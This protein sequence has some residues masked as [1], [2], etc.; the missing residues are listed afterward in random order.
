[1]SKQSNNIK[2][3]VAEII[4][5]FQTAPEQA[6]EQLIFSSYYFHKQSKNFW[7]AYMKLDHDKLGKQ[8]PDSVDTFN[9]AVWLKLF[10]DLNEVY[11]TERAKNIEGLITLN[12]DETS[13][14]KSLFLC[15]ELG[16]TSNQPCS[17]PN[18]SEESLEAIK[19]LLKE[20]FPP[21]TS[22]NKT[23][24]SLEL[25]QLS[26]NLIKSQVDIALLTEFLDAFVWAGF[27]MI[28]EDCSKGFVLSLPDGK[29]KTENLFVLN[30]LK[31]LV[32]RDFK[33]KES[34]PK[35]SEEEHFKKNDPKWKT[36]E[37]LATVI[38]SSNMTVTSQTPGTTSL[39]VEDDSMLTDMTSE[40]P[41]KRDEAI[42]KMMLQS[43]EQNFHYQ[44]RHAL[45]LIY[46]PNDEIDTHALHLE[47]ETDIFVS[48]YDLLCSMS[49]IIAR[50][51]A[52]RYISEFPNSGSIKSIKRGVWDLISSQKQELT[53]QE[54]ENLTNTEVV[55]HF[56]MFDEHYEQKIFYFFSEENILDLFAKVEELKTKSQKELKAIINLLSSFNS[57]LP[58]NPLYKVDNTFYFSYHTCSKFNLNRFLYDNYISDK[59]F[60][61]NNKANKERP[62][63]EETQKNREIRFTNSLKELF[64]TITPFVESRL[65]FG[66][67]NSNYDF[68][69]LKGEFDVIAYF[70]KEN[71]IFPIQVKLSNV[72]PRSEKRKEEW[73]L[74]RITGKGIKQVKKDVKLLQTKSGL[75]FVADKLKIGNRKEINQPIIYPII[76]S[77][78]FFADHIS[79]P[80]NE[81]DDQVF[82]VSYF[83]LKHLILNQK[84]HDKQ[85]D[86]LPFDNGNSASHLIE[87]IETNVFWD[88]LNVFA[89]NFKFSKT[90][91]AINEE[92]K[93]EMKV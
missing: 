32:K 73:I 46:Q 27:E 20:I 65:E 53:I 89:E 82:C 10:Y 18:Y 22:E 17:F 50:A 54:K 64:Q 56:K 88:F 45:S 78:N 83:E 4:Q 48:L 49:C 19:I 74:Q 29:L 69:E 25:A 76:V 59:L 26:N 71:I 1:M 90:L 7:D 86:W 75:K 5:L 55:H 39:Q 9:K 66:A 80:Y 2:V 28:K 63:I 21:L 33:R 35:I 70:E 87:V 31:T 84:I 57:P 81:N 36:Q 91:T 79:F 77:D 52:F 24:Y 12:P 93:I 13:F 15:L 14:T 61:P 68:G 58:F 92:L 43:Q 23:S 34:H 47:I 8:F 30:H 72:S 11:K 37:G 3:S 51:D 44:Y 38:H 60:N 41:K 6:Y 67:P 40:D 85:K 16:E 42:L 62:L